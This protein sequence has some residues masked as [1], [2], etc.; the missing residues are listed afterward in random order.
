MSVQDNLSKI[1][2]S[3]PDGVTLVAVTKFRSVET[4]K[5]AYDL[6]QRIFGENR[7]QELIAKQPLLPD[8]IDWRLI[9]SL[10]TNKVKYI[11]PFIS[12]IQSVDT[13]KLIQEINRQAEKCNRSIRVLLEVHIAK[14]DSK[15]GFSPEECR[16]LFSDGIPGKFS[17]IQIC[18]LMGMATFTDDREQTRREFR[19]LKH[20]FDEI[21][22]M[23]SIDPSMFSELSMGMSDD[24]K[25]AI[26]EGATMVRIGSAIFH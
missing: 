16:N 12:M 6:G 10:Q 9:G 26:E 25:I 11:A 13:L 2:A 23:P 19:T 3:L 17:N 15:H 4:I 8:D 14:E 5:E 1:L 18:G 24:Y 20:L 21:R 7:V 22:T